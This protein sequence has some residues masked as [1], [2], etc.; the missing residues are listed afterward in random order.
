MLSL[1]SQPIC[2]SSQ[3]KVL[4]GTTLS[5]IYIQQ[6][7]HISHMNL[8]IYNIMPTAHREKQPQNMRQ[9]LAQESC[10]IWKIIQSFLFQTS[11]HTIHTTY[12]QK[13]ITLLPKE[14]VGMRFSMTNKEKNWQD[15]LR[16]FLAGAHHFPGPTKDTQ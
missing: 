16:N 6:A 13:C 15:H 10:D 7:S 5:H 8:Q 2:A 14:L 12:F 1:I 4:T 3:P 9:M 11:T